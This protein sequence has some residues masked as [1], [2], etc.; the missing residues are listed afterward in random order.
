VHEFILGRH[1]Q[2]VFEFSDTQPYYAVAGDSMNYMPVAGMSPN[3]LELQF[4][5]GAWIAW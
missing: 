5:G 4:R 1:V 2:K 3:D